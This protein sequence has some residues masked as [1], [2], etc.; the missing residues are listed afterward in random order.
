[1][2]LWAKKKKKKDPQSVWLSDSDWESWFSQ[3]GIVR[4]GALSR[5]EAGMS[6]QQVTDGSH[7][8]WQGGIGVSV[9][10]WTVTLGRRC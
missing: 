6:L 10:A 2:I 8:L 9:P 4:R 1:M 3:G 5:Q 7:A